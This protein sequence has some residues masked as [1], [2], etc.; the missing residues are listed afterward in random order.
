M[1]SGD[2]HE[3]L[4]KEAA[5]YIPPD[6]CCCCCCCGGWVDGLVAVALTELPRAR[7]GTLGGRVVVAVVL[8]G[9]STG[10]TSAVVIVVVVVGVVVA[11]VASCCEGVACGCS[12]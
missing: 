12:G 10:G 3:A 1:L 9:E 11:V 8:T 2:D 4:D 6:C 5:E 7:C